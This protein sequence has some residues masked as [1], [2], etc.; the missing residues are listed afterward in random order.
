MSIFVP[1]LNFEDDLGG[2]PRQMS[3]QAVRVMNELAPLMGLLGQ[4]GDRVLVNERAMPTDVARCLTHVT[5]VDDSNFCAKGGQH[6]VI[7]WGWTEQTRQMASNVQMPTTEIPSARAVTYVNSRDFSAKLDAVECDQDSLLPFGADS[8]GTICRSLNEWESGVR[9][10]ERFRFSRW[11]AKPQISHAGRNRL[12]AS[13]T[14]LNS[15]QIGWLMKH[16][17]HR[18]GVYLEPWVRPEEEC[19][20][21]FEIIPP[22][23]V[24]RKN[25]CRVR[26]VG[27]SG[28]LNDH[29]GRYQGS[30]ICQADQLDSVWQSAVTHGFSV[31]EAAAAAGY[32]G[33][34]GI[35]S[36]RFHLPDGSVALRMCN[37]VNARFTMGRLALQLRSSLQSLQ[38]GAWCHFGVPDFSRFCDGVRKRL[39]QPAEENVS[40]IITS[41]MLVG[42]RLIRSGT[43]LFAGDS[44]EPL[45]RT[46]KSIRDQ[47]AD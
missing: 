2:Q 43:I 34:I 28:L 29:V 7:P 47:A 15:Q 42:G 27:V 6:R 38:F 3:G 46:V 4:N 5:F 17:A 13:G 12:L 20:L 9:Q 32:F 18:G 45:L 40:M 30:L 23:S 16:L 44:P 37:D 25:G 31:C 24:N 26:L 11:V 36:F 1:N 39:T 35:D 41:P 19:G 21:Q 10:L 8:F 14:E 22:C 33:P